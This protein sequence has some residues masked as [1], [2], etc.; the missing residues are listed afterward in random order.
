[1]S[2]IHSKTTREAQRNNDFKMKLQARKDSFFQSDFIQQFPIVVLACSN[3]IQNHEKNDRE[4]DCIFGVKYSGEFK[5]YSKGNWFYVHYNSNKTKLV[6]H[7]RQLSANVEND[8]LT[9]IGNVVR[10]FKDREL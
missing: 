5:E 3:Y 2:N 4:I 1:M 7:T 10:Q 6:I 9:G 8:L